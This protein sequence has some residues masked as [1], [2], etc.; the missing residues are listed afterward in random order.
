MWGWCLF[1]SCWVHLRS[2]T[3][4]CSKT[5]RMIKKCV[6]KHSVLCWNRSHIILGLIAG[7][8]SHP[9]EI[10]AAKSSFFIWDEPAAS[11]LRPAD[12]LD[13]PPAHYHF[14]NELHNSG[15]FDRLAFRRWFAK[16]NFWT[17]IQMQTGMQRLQLDRTQNHFLSFL[18]PK[19]PPLLRRLRTIRPLGQNWLS[20]LRTEYDESGLKHNICPILF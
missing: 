14:E 11:Q 12:W 10:I 15:S 16:V 20:I 7:S 2:L 13:G 3:E 1:D 17:T 19:N 6:S 8:F 5:F 4:S 18:E 9:F